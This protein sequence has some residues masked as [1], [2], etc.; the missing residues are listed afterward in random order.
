MMGDS[1]RL[2]R[3]LG[4]LRTQVNDRFPGRS[5]IADGTIGDAAHRARGNK[6]DH[7]PWVRL[8][9]LGIVTALDLTHSPGKGVDT[10]A[11]AEHLRLSRDR[12]IKYVVSQRR[13]F[14]STN[15]PW[16]WRAYSGTPHTGHIHISVSA[17]TS[18]FDDH[19]DWSIAFG[20]MADN[21]PDAQRD[22]LRRGSTGADVRLVQELLKVP[23]DGIFGSMTE[24]AVRAFQMTV[25]IRV[26]G[27]VGART[28]EHLEF[29]E[30]IEE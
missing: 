3:A 29:L 1:W 24:A 12:R 28:W 25:H 18:L 21:A 20:L 23:V 2:A 17:T 11:L 8:G 27:V 22:V 7:N 15:T 10:Y 6:S 19:R 30:E 14:S 5:K 26:D 16:E 9:H 13:I 4:R